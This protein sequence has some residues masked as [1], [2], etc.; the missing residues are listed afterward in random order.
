MLSCLSHALIYLPIYV[1]WTPTTTLRTGL[2]QIA[3]CLVSFL[4]LLCYIS[5]PVFNASSVD[6]IL[7][8]LIGVYTVCQCPFYRT[9]GINGLYSIETAMAEPQLLRQRGRCLGCTDMYI[10]QNFNCVACF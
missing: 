4:F 9:L 2:F 1:G 8:R 10:D 5:T 7:R 6:H 3:G